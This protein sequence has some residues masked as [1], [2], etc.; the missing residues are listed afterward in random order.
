MYKPDLTLV[1]KTIKFPFINCG[2]HIRSFITF[3]AFLQRLKKTLYLWIA[4]SDL[5]TAH[6]I[7]IVETTC[8]FYPHACVCI[9]LLFDYMLKIKFSVH[10]CEKSANYNYIRGIKFVK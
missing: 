1:Y 4:V 7:C 9:L 10:E 8:K 6:P 2:I 5:R 3:Q